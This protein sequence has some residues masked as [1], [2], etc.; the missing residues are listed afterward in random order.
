[1]STVAAS[2][3]DKIARIIGIRRKNCVASLPINTVS[4]TD[5]T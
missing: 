1:L 4:L 3:S 2:T 5:S